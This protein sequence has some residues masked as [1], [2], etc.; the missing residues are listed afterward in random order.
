MQDKFTGRS[1]MGYPAEQPEGTSGDRYGWIIRQ[2]E[3][4]AS[5][6]M[7][8]YWD[9]LNE[10]RID[11]KDIKIPAGYRVNLEEARHGIAIANYKLISSKTDPLSDAEKKI[12]IEA[13]NVFCARGYPVNVN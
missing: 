13:F 12:F 6:F 11:N 9:K 4:W 2:A 3:R 1:E 5:E 10:E 8:G 7:E